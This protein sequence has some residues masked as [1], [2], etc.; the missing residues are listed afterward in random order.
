MFDHRDGGCRAILESEVL[1][2]LK[3]P[4]RLSHHG[5][6]ILEGDV[7]PRAVQETKLSARVQFW[8]PWKGAALPSL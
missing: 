2:L 3:L 8:L 1:R 6:S 5:R 7:Q 4:P